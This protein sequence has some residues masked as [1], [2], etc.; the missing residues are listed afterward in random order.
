MTPEQ[1]RKRTEIIER[2]KRNNETAR[3]QHIADKEGVM[4]QGCGCWNFIHLG[5]CLHT[6]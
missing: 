6:V 3:I 1:A 4:G 5:H 2:A